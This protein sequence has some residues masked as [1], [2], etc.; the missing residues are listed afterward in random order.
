[1]EAPSMGWSHPVDILVTFDFDA[2]TFSKQRSEGRHHGPAFESHGTF[3]PKVGIWRILDSLQARGVLATFFVPGWVAE[4]WPEVIR[5]VMGRG[6]EIGL[7]GYLHEYPTAMV[8]EAQERMVVERAIGALEAVTGRKTEGYRPPGF[9]YSNHSLTLLRGYGFIY[10]SSMQDDDGA[11]IHQEPD[12]HPLVEIPCLWHLC[13]DLFGWHADV[14][15]PPSQVEEHWVSEL[16]EI[17][18][19]PGRT[20]VLTLHPQLMGH[21]GRLAMLERVLDEAAGLGGRF[22]R[23]IEVAREL[24]EDP[25]HAE[26][27]P[28][29]Q[30]IGI[31]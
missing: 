2:E 28:K 12:A 22:R 10:G 23:C 9:L 14:R 15:L 21:P 31:S 19:Y 4:R 3:G 29:N 1:M 8:D 13:D 11:Y 20:Y 30:E 17:G 7:H 18:R 16:R 27:I 6:H 5:E 26:G 24:L 25:G